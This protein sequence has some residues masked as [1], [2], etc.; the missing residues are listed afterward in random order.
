MVES[1]VPR[2]KE[3]HW[4]QH[5]CYIVEHKV[6]SVMARNRVSKRRFKGEEQFLKVVLKAELCF[7]RYVHFAYVPIYIFGP[8]HK[9]CA[10]D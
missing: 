10:S 7:H 6:C 9:V 3:V 4:L 8:H 5:T 1:S 2:H